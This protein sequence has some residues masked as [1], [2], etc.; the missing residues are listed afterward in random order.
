[1]I[2]NL[3][4]CYDTLTLETPS[5]K[6]IKK[7]FLTEDSPIR[8]SIY[9]LLLLLL[10]FVRQLCKFLCKMLI[11]KHHFITKDNTL[12]LKKSDS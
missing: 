7:H 5:K 12:V 9:T 2:E 10:F 6:M 4:H 8:A 3:Q 11:K 1:M